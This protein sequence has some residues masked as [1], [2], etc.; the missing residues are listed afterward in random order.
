MNQYDPNAVCRWDCYQRMTMLEPL[1]AHVL[2]VGGCRSASHAFARLLSPSLTFA[3]L[4]SL[5]PP[6]SCR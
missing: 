5:S 4:L 2:Q 1:A 6:T 3:R